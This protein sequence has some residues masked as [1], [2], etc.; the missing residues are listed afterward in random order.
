MYS[1]DRK[2]VELNEALLKLNTTK[3]IKVS[4]ELLTT[5]I[6]VLSGANI[7]D[8][9]TGNDTVII[10]HPVSTDPRPGPPGPQGPAGP[11][12]PPGEC[13]CSRNTTL[14]NA[15]YAVS[16]SDYYVGVICDTPITVTLPETPENGYSV[17]IKLEM[18]P[19][20]GNRKVTVVTSDGSLI[21]AVTS[22]ELKTPYK[23]LTLLYRNGWHAL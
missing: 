13:D 12:G 17:I 4:D 22:V 21:D 14:I 19:P 7:V 10:G 23:A 6:R 1:L 9:G 16:H 3:D 2:L 18:G 11:P 15:D 20:I 5:A 8:T